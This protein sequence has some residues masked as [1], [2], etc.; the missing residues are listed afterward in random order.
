MSPAP[1]PNGKPID[2]DPAKDSVRPRL[3]ILRSSGVRQLLA[4]LLVAAAYLIA[5]RLG[6][7]LAFT[8]KS[9]SPVWPP[10]GIALAGLLLLGYRA[11]PGVFLGAFLANY[12]L[13][14]VSLLTATGIAGG[15]TLEALTAAILLQRFVEPKKLFAHA[16]NVLKFVIIAVIFSTAISATIGNLTLLLAGAE[17]ANQFGSLWLT[18]WL[19]DAV[20]ALVV[21]PLVLTWVERPLERYSVSRLIETAA[22]IVALSFIS[23]VIFT[24]FV[25]DQSRHYAIGHLIIPVLLWVAFRF[26]PR[27]GATAITLVSAIAIWGTTH[28]LGPYALADQ[29]R[30]LLLLQ[31]FIADIAITTLVLATVVRERKSA[32]NVLRQQTET[33]QLAHAFARDLDDVI[34]VWYA[35]AE[36][37]YGFTATEAVGRRSHELLHTIHPQ[38]LEEIRRK[39]FWDGTWEGEL[40]HRAKDGKQLTVASHFSLYRDERGRPAGILEVNNDITEE[41]RTEQALHESREWLR[42]TMEGSRMGTWT[43]DL[44]DTNRVQ[45]SPELER[46]FGLS[47]GGFSQTEEEF[48][49]FVHSDDRARLAEAVR[50]A[51]E[52]KTDYDIE[53]RY[54]PKGGGIR[55]MLGRGRALYDS[56]GK[57]YRLAG[58]GWD[59]TERKQVEESLVRNQEALQLAHKVA[60]GGTWQWDLLTNAVEWSEE[61]YGL[62]GLKSDEVQPSFE[63]WA[64][65]VHPDDLPIVFQEHERAIAAKRD[66]D[67]EFRIKRAD[68][69]W[70]WFHRTGRCV[71]DANGQ[72]LSMAGITFDITERRR[73]QEATRLLAAIVESTD[74][75]IIGKD[76]NGIIT[77]WN[78][79]AEKLYGYSAEEAIGQPVSILVPPE[80]P[81]EEEEILARL[82]RGERIHHYETVRLNKDGRRIDVSLTVSPIVDKTGRVIG[83][84]KIARDITEWKRAEEAIRE[85]QAQLANMI[86]S[87][88][89]AVITLDEHQQ[90]VIFNSAAE[91][92]FRCS[93]GEAIGQP[94]DRFIPD[95]FRSAHH[96][97]IRTFEETHVTRRSM[98]QLGAIF[99]LRADGEEFPIEA[100]ISQVEVNGRSLFT[101]ILRDITQRKSVEEER[102]QL[103]ASEHAARTEAEAANRTKDEF[104][105]MLS[106]ELRTPL[107]AMLGWLSILRSQ[108]VDEKTFAHGIEAVERNAK[109]Q[110][111]LI[112]DL[113]DV[114]RIIGGKLS[115]EVR[116]IDLSPVIRAAIEVVRPAADAKGVEIEFCEE[117]LVGPVSG[118]AT[119]LRQVVWNLLSNAVKFTPREGRVNVSLRRFK[120]QAQIVVSDSGAGIP[121]EFLP[122]VFER[123]RQAESS[124]TRSHRG[125][126]LGLAIVRHLVELHGGTVLAES[127][128]QGKGA[129]FTISLPLAAISAKKE[130]KLPMAKPK[131]EE[132]VAPLLGLRVLVVEDE[133]DAGELISLALEYSGAKVEVARSAQ[134]G[135]RAMSVFKPDVLLSDI[136]LPGE[137]GYDLIRKI[138]SM[139]SGANEIPA[140]A[141]T[142]FA[143]ERDRESALAAGFQVH[144]SKPV[145]PH[146]LVKVIERLANRRR[147]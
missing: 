35:G 100:S 138:R 60:R 115:L 96:E 143:S 123:F 109:I 140:V 56:S 144:L 2:P 50:A 125:L 39:L 63:E 128:G 139:A 25:L 137:S 68:G 7:S 136:G 118:D 106:H 31:A 29:N 28:S 92:M 104:L 132:A 23:A 108:S 88:M 14:P 95:R 70:R 117:P 147:N 65:R 97:H 126:G 49:E 48:F 85:S 17:T 86:G 90:I 101:V 43:R 6:L 61:Y 15:N 26:G 13:T 38:P 131:T 21:T 111:H 19:G 54:T 22:S 135:L 146:E 44:D 34:T 121:P 103:L 52:N 27:G 120:S 102:E 142:A 8:N 41:K 83:A 134:D 64:R 33:L 129:T 99:G 72:A 30:A 62:L 46:M 11:S 119:R 24:N 78:T 69:E 141:L 91:K 79:A 42:M 89:D 66:I 12:F 93:A 112:E 133:F 16:A 145:Q 116:P 73:A 113:V 67:V 77:S 82:T 81:D 114:S 51:I 47:P 80:R 10:T 107:T 4:M 36:K 58:L 74:D 127:E 37:L 110:A 122:H 55:W 5:A 53:F 84:S 124:V 76:L 94:I 59:I 18:W 20:G 40:V 3:S 75:V 9:V 45:W 87:A 32:E 57:P 71:Y 105:A 130:P 98:G 1:E